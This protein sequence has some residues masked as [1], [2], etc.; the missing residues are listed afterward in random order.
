[1]AAP[2][3]EYGAFRIVRGGQSASPST[4]ELLDAVRAT[5]ADELL[6]LPNNPNVMLAAR[7]VATMADVPVHVVPTRNCAEGVAALLEL[8]PHQSAED[9]AGAMTEASRAVQTMQVTAAVRD[10]T[11]SGRKVRKGQTIVL[12]PDDGLLAADN[13]AMRAVLAG[14]A[15]LEPGFGLVTVYYGEDATLDEAETLALRMREAAPGVDVEVVY[16]GQPHYRY[17]VSAE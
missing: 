13:D 1:M 4:G 11:V 10:A 6:I 9:N 5:T 12:D 7:Q 17:L 14:L 3:R 15:R 16:G 8:N 2:F